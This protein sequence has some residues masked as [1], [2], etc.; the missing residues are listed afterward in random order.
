MAQTS[1]EQAK[2]S[3]GPEKPKQEPVYGNIDNPDE[4]GVRDLPKP[5]TT[6]T[7][8]A[9]SDNHYKAPYISV[10]YDAKSGDALQSRADSAYSQPNTGKVR[11]VA[12][13]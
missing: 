9:A 10:P 8:A 7:T 4:A 3:E 11:H 13:C 5:T 12:K 2:K 6:T 1:T